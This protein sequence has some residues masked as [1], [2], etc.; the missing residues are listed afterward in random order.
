MPVGEVS[1]KLGAPSYDMLRA[2]LLSSLVNL[3]DDSNAVKMG[4][5][6]VGIEQDEGTATA[7]LADGSRITGDLVIGADGIHS[8]IRNAVVGKSKLRYSGYSAVVAVIPFTHPLLPKG[9]HVE[10]WGKGAKAGVADVGN[11]QVRWYVTHKVPTGKDAAT[12]K[13]EILERI[14]GWYELLK[15]AVDS[16]E[17]S[18]LVHTEA[19]DLKSIKTWVKGRVVLL[20][21]AAHATTPFAAMGANITIEDSIR[22]AEL[23]T[24]ELSLDDALRAFQEHRKKRTEDVV[25]KSRMM[26]KIAQVHSPIL[27]WLRDQA[28]LHISPEKMEQVALEMASGEG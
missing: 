2:G 16:T 8:V 1:R 21:D 24:S 28:F 26:A 14:K 18:L 27:A 12:G 25:K 17:D 7:V 6:C 22:L 5:E 23:L 15:A 19:W 9:H 11:D 10:I 20:G 4:S 13:A 3:I